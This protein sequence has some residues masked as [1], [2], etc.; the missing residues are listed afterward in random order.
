VTAKRTGVGVIAAWPILASVGLH[1]VLVG[2]AVLVREAAPERPV[3]LPVTLELRPAPEHPVPHEPVAP[4]VPAPKSPVPS[5]PPKKI[6]P[7]RVVSRVRKAAPRPA[8]VRPSLPKLHEATPP[9][10]VAAATAPPL[11]VGGIKEVGEGLNIPVGD[12]HGSPHGHP[13]GVGGLADVPEL[14]SELPLPP[15]LPPPPPPPP[16]PPAPEVPKK[17]GP[18]PLS[19]LS[20]RPKPVDIAKAEY[21]IEA[22]RAGREG[23]VVISLLLD[24][25]GAVREATVKKGLGF[26]LDEAARAALLRS[27]FTPALD[28]TGEPVAT[29]ITYKY[30]FVLD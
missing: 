11:G 29:R 16:P 1:A 26:G 22:R 18:V 15:V 3:Y 8:A 2:A 14:P 10:R 7:R 24:E 17:R 20:R 12:P 21:P 30:E 6:A 5:P 19:E 4:K 28:R 25:T 27:R 13:H 23:V 9:A